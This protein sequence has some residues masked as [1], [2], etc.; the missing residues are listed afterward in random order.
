MSDDIP[1]IVAIVGSRDF[2][3]D[4]EVFASITR[5][6]E[7]HGTRLRVRTGDAAGVDTVVWQQAQ[8]IGVPVDREIAHWP[9]R[10]P[11]WDDARYRREKATAGSERN[12]RV[13]APAMILIA[14]FHPGA[15]TELRRSSSGT[16][17]AINQA[18][19]KGIPVHV[20]HEGKWFRDI[21]GSVARTAIA[22]WQ[23]PAIPGFVHDPRGATECRA[24]GTPIWWSKNPATDKV[25]PF[26][27]SGKAHVC[28][29]APAW[30]K[31]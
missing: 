4:N 13:V 28:P 26:E 11:D 2:F 27:A 1:V 25:R 7:R 30:R 5:L 31:K 22:K 23:P 18:F 24:C 12:A 9:D 17:N 16:A 3:P 20:F 21:P 19:S 10:D 29:N 8:I 6:S 15:I 14:F